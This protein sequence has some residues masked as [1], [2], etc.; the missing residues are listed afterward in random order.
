MTTYNLDAMQFNPG[1]P[2]VFITEHTPQGA[3]WWA[4]NRDTDDAAAIVE[5]MT[6]AHAE[7]AAL[8]AAHMQRAPV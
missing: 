8:H 5:F 2:P 7:L 1:P 3:D 6:S 4:T